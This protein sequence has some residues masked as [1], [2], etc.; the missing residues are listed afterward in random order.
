M[1]TIINSKQK[2]LAICILIGGKSSRFGT[3][4]AG[5]KLLGK[6]LIIHQIETLSSFD[7]DV[8]LV[9]SS[10]KQIL[11]FKKQIEFPKE[12][13]YITDKREKFP[14]P[15]ISTPILG[16]YS[17]FFELSQKEFRKTMILSGDMPLID[18]EVIKLLIDEV[19][20]YDCCIPRW[21]NGYLE[22]LCAIY[23]VEKAL[24]KTKK[25]IKERNFN[26][27]EILEED[28]NINYIPVEEKIKLLDKNLLSFINVNGPIDLEKGIKLYKKELI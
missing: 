24:E 27:T 22:P 26:L 11:K 4:K 13:K 21:S 10:D 5:I 16:F 15:E 17:A 25:L 28:W 14:Y 7:E 2:E 12:I 9:A 19:E 3:E 1:K 8:Y 6:P 18:P 23:P 20:G